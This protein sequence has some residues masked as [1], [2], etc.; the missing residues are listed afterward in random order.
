MPTEQKSDNHLWIAAGICLFLIVLVW[1]VFGQ[2]LGYNFVNYDDDIYV[3]KN[4]L[5]F[6]GLTLRGLRWAFTGSH[7][8]NWH[9]LTTISHMLDCQLFGLNPGG[10]HFVN[11]LLHTIAV[12]LL[13]RVLWQMTGGPSRTGSIWPSAFV[14][15]VFAIH[16]LRVE[17]V[18]WIAE[19]K[20]VLS[21]V[22]F[23]L[24]LGAY[25]CYVRR[26]TVG[27]YIAMSILYGLGLMAKPMLVTLPFVLLLLDY[28]PLQ[29]LSLERRSIARAIREK[30]PLFALAI[31]SSVITLIVQSQAMNEIQYLPLR[32]RLS[33]AFLSYLTYAWQM[34]WPANLAVFY[35]YTSK[36][37][38]AVMAAIIILGAVTARV[39]AVNRK[40]PYLVTGWFWYVAMLV[41]VI[42]LVQVGVQGHADRYTYLPSI[43]LILALTWGVLDLSKTWRQR[44]RLLGVGAAALLGI[45]SW[46]ARE[47]T[48]SWRDSG[49]L[50]RHALAVTQNNYI[51]H[52][53]LAQ[54]LKTGDEAISHLQETLKVQPGYTF[55]HYDLGRIFADKGELDKAIDEFQKTV[56]MDRYNSGAW[57]GLGQAFLFKGKAHEATRY[58]ERALEVAPESVDSLR[59][60]AWILATCP[61]PSLRNGARAIELAAKAVGL[62]RGQNPNVLRSLAAAYA[63]TGRFNEA[64]VVARQA[65]QLALA[66]SN[67]ELANRLKLELDLY[68]TNLPLRDSSLKTSGP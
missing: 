49:T 24:T 44:P 20:D 28:W 18:A 31:A 34:F 12:L 9:P 43:G 21:G 13:F 59:G 66:Q 37:H 27:R 62:S 45:L 10:P 60:L 15:A 35:P 1:L 11:V 65:L 26:P 6:S 42:G 68:Q 50:W 64:T 57:A 22:F 46:S 32:M 5:V 40:Y 39:L 16:P 67:A 63:E 55:A 23:M 19:R 58:Y 41:P 2:T 29:R 38:L 56:A 51:A 54:F 7:A 61:D 48:Q 53:K 8:V 30:I 47:Q 36:G 3:Y 17:S 4:P 14:A 25:A 52:H 33:N